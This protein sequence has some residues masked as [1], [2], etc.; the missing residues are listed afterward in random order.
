MKTVVK[1]FSS[2]CDILGTLLIIR[3]D[4]ITSHTL[5]G[6]KNQCQLFHFGCHGNPR[7]EI[8][9]VNFL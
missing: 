8:V 7:P 5:S 1:F 2:N 4:I 6:F 9:M 3:S